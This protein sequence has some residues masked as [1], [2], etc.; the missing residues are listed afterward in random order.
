MTEKQ[1]MLNGELYNHYDDELTSERSKVALLLHDYNQTSDSN[2]A[3]NLLS[4]ILGKMGKDVEFKRS[5]VCDYGYNIEVGDHV[6]VNYDCIFLDCSKI[7]IG[8]N[9]LIAPNVQFY[10]AT[11]PTDYRTRLKGLEYALPIIIGN[12]VWIGGGAIICPGIHIG[13]NTT[14]G[15]GSIVTSNIPANCIAVGNPCKVL[16]MLTQTEE[17]EMSNVIEFAGLGHINIVVDNIDEGINFYKKLLHAKPYQI[18]RNYKNVGFSKAAGFLDNPQDISLHLAFLEIPS[19]GLTLELM[20]YINPETKKNIIRNDVNM[21]S[22]VRHVALEVKNIDEA[23]NYVSSLDGVS[24][25]NP[26]DD[27]LPYKIDSIKESEFQF[28]DK[29]LEQNTEKKQNVCNIIG[30]TRYFYFIDPYGVQWEFEQGHTDVGN[31]K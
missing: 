28:F 3:T 27:Y 24:L 4:K 31:N 22:G 14:I 11:H 25:I 19:T 21:I 9:V 10:T 1:K 6:F 26:S 7:I 20:Q 13:N 17:A 8:S 16:R 12:N 5:F 29:A 2:K 18:F 30:N 15:A 23:F